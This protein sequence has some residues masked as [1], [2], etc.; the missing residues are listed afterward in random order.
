MALALR[1][2]ALATGKRDPVQFAHFSVINPP[3]EAQ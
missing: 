1:W 2:I 3:C